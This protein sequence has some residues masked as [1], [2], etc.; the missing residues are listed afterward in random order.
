M[1]TD[2]IE[3]EWAWDQPLIQEILFHEHCWFV[4]P[5]TNK[6][7]KL[8][9]VERMYGVQEISPLLE[10]AGFTAISTA[11]RLKGDTPAQAGKHFA[12]WC[13]KPNG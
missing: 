12:F 8:A 3:I 6:V 1:G 2:T 4:Y 10:E 9:E 5:E 7:I 13:R 11:R